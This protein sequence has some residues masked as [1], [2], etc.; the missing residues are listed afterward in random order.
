[1]IGYNVKRLLGL[2]DVRQDEL[3]DIL[4][5]S[6]Q[7]VN[8]IIVGRSEPSLK[9][10]KAMAAAFE[11]PIDALMTDDVNDCL[12]IGIKTL[13]TA[14]IGHYRK[15]S[16]EGQPIDPGRMRDLESHVQATFAAMRDKKAAGMPASGKTRAKPRGT[17]STKD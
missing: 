16:K 15:H 12:N 10:L 17:R 3:A 1:M 8:N 4:G 6:K 2:H 13:T 7:G 9:T 14:P 5:L 11:V